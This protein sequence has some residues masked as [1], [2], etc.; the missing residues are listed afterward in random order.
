M[1]CG[2][3]VEKEGCC[4]FKQVM[5]SF[6]KAEGERL[7]L[8]AVCNTARGVFIIQECDREGEGGAAEKDGLSEL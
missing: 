6:L 4:C 3:G 1:P 5:R 7:R 2:G 8:S